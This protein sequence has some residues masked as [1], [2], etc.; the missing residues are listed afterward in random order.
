MYASSD[1]RNHVAIMKN[2]LH[3][4]TIC[5]VSCICGSESGVNTTNYQVVLL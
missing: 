1:T 4:D 3:H 5:V 2:K